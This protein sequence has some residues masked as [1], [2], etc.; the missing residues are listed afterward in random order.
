M[1]EPKDKRTKEYKEWKAKYKEANSKGAGD[2]IE[3]ITE[4]TGIKKLVKFIA[5]E[6]CGCDERKQKLNQKVRFQ[7]A[8]CPTEQQYNFMKDLFSRKQITILKSEEQRQVNTILNDVFNRRL[9]HTSCGSCLRNRVNDLKQL[10]NS[11]K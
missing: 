11:Y 10:Y 8:K 3:T 4:K 5:G 6:D 9:T 1:E 7:I 2:V